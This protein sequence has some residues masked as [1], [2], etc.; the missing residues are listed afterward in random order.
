MVILNMA[1]S[2]WQKMTSGMKES[3]PPSETY[4]RKA[5]CV[6]FHTALVN[7]IRAMLQEELRA[8]DVEH[9]ERTDA[10]RE[11]LS[12]IVGGVHRRVDVIFQQEGKH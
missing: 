2:L 8:L 10:L 12:A 7:E 11:E 6:Q 1:I 4:Q 5:D 9:R 3:P